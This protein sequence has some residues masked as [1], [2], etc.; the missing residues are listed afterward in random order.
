MSEAADLV[1]ERG[2]IAWMAKHAVT[3][4]LLMLVLLLGGAYSCLTIKQEVF[5]EFELDQVSVS[6][7]Y[8][9]ASPEEVERGVILAVEEAVRGIEGVKK[10][11][12]RANENA[13]NISIELERGANNDRAAQD[14]QNAIDRITTFPE[15]AER[16]TVALQTIRRQVVNLIIYGDQSEETLRELAER[17]RFELLR[18]PRIT[19]VDVTG[20][21]PLEIAVELPRETLRRYGLTL[22][23][24]ATVV[25][26]AA[27]DLPGGKVEA[28]GGDILLRLAERR[29]LGTQFLAVPLLSRPDGTVVR[30]GDVAH[31]RDGFSEVDRATYFSGHPAVVLEVYRIG[32]QTPLEV[33]AIVAEFAAGLKK[34]LP[35]GVSVSLWDDRSEIYSQRISLLLRNAA[36][37]LFLV[38]LLLGCFLQVRLAF[39]V[40]M[41][42][43]VSFLGALLIL[44]ALGVSIDMISL[45]AFIIALGIV[46]DDA[47]VVGD[48]VFEYREGGMPYLKSAILGAR[49]VDSPVVFS[50]L[51]NMVS[52]I[53]LWFVPDVMGKIFAVI[54]SVVVLVFGISL[55]ESL[56]ILPAHL[57]HQKPP[58]PGGLWA[59]LNCVERFF[60]RLLA[61]FVAEIYGP[62]VRLAVRLRYATTAAFVTILIL[63]AAYVASGRIG[64]EAFPR[65][66]SDIVV[67]GLELP[68][69]TPVVETEQY[70]ARLI[71]AAREVIAAH[72]GDRIL[73]GIYSQIGYPPVRH[74][75]GG[76][77][78]VDSGS[79]QCNVYVFMVPED[80][81]P[82]TSQ[83]FVDEWRERFGSPPGLESL[84]FLSEMGG[85]S[86]GAAIEV[87]LD[88]QD[89]PELEA[90][91]AKLATVVAGYGGVKDVN[92]GV[93]PGKRQLDFKLKPAARA[94]GVTASDLGRQVR[95][96]YYGSEALRLQRGR[97]EL[98]VMV[99]L[100]E[101][102]RKS[103]KGLE[104]LLIRAPAGAEIPLREA[105]EVHSGHAYNSIRRVDGRRVVSV[106]ADIQPRGEAGKVLAD[107]K[108]TALPELTER[109]PGLGYSFEGAQR[110]L[111]DSFAA[112]KKGFVMAL[113]VVFALLAI[114]FNSYF[115]P[116]IVMVS[117]PF[118]IVGAVLGHLIMGYDLSIMSM[119]G[120]VAL[121]GVVVNDSLVLIDY[122][123]QLR[124]AGRTSAEAVCLAG[125][126]RLRPI[127]LTSLTTFGGL[128]P[129]IFEKSIQAKFMIPMALSLGYGI[130]FATVIALI[131]VPSLYVI[132]E[133]GTRV[134]GWIWNRED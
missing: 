125:E 2:A 127:I 66:A 62:A 13:A 71:T 4:N 100:P 22:D 40:M 80:E 97:E 11:E 52:F 73:R 92:D 60:G 95:A 122:A 21:R 18:N 123:N 51:T 109:Y 15:E 128:M 96:A 37:G 45:F 120:L 87:Q 115:Q 28:A 105:A 84:T 106:T 42:I 59:R 36:Q 113:L 65:V 114:P 50:V 88:H 47:I 83:Q 86:A 27:L 107:L 126:R 79:H 91:A 129:M 130:L 67:A 1:E 134:W 124:D 70:Q 58:R 49:G 89:I 63:T 99:R 76:G 53:P 118:G 5:P 44:P 72:G 98:K 55:V 104:D 20:T 43:P 7:P 132:I 112:L 8:P 131:L 10:V 26:Q 77:A 121:S 24:V 103:L 17:A 102:E 16:P 48:N 119:M 81:R 64:L 108:Q 110:S 35:A 69:G 3:A 101:A 68:F 38:M 31:I 25:R 23:Q 30:L 6:V 90:A 57:G 61:K 85:P 39:W 34:T 74:G 111:D 75:P 116:A 33:S 117:I 9:G 32:D 19:Q 54:P 94:L 56:F 78:T 12:A 93:T 41:G 82:V 29:E 46:V 133:D 14:I